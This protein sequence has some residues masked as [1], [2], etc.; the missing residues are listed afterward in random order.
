MEILILMNRMNTFLIIHPDT[1]EEEPVQVEHGAG[2]QRPLSPVTV[3]SRP[4]HAKMTLILCV[5][6]TQRPMQVGCQLLAGQ[7]KASL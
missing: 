3:V 7:G 2:P 6:E 5:N 4:V 1:P